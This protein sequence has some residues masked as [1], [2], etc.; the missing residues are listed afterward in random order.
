MISCPECGHRFSAWK[1]GFKKKKSRTVLRRDGHEYIFLEGAQDKLQMRLKIYANAG[2]EAILF[3]DIVEDIRPA[4][5]QGCVEPHE[6]SWAGQGAPKGEW[7]HNSKSKG[8]RRCDGA[9]CALFTCKPFHD[10]WHNR[11]IAVSQIAR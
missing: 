11:V 1:R 10:R 3:D 4:I 2:G 6:I 7:F 5:C 9:C 8:G